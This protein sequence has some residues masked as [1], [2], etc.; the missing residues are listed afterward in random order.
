MTQI[1]REKALSEVIFRFQEQQQPQQGMVGNVPT[2]EE[3]TKA[4]KRNPRQT[5][6][7]ASTLLR[8]EILRWFKSRPTQTNND[9]PWQEPLGNFQT[10]LSKLLRL[11]CAEDIA[12]EDP[13]Q[14]KKTGRPLG[15]KHSFRQLWLKLDL[16]LDESAF[17][18]DAPLLFYLT[19]YTLIE[20]TINKVTDQELSTART[21]LPTHGEHLETGEAD[22][23]GDVTNEGDLEGYDQAPNES[24]LPTLQEFCSNVWQI[25]ALEL[26]FRPESNQA[27][28]SSGKTRPRRTAISPR[29][30]FIAEEIART[31]AEKKGLDLKKQMEFAG[32]LIDVLINSF[33]E[34]WFEIVKT[35]REDDNRSTKIQVIMPTPV[36]LNIIKQLSQETLTISH[37][38]PLIEPPIDWGRHGIQQGGYHYRHLPFYKF[39]WKNQKINEFLAK[40]N[41]PA[42][43]SEV[44][45]ATNVLQRTPWCIN[46]KV[47]RVVEAFYALAKVTLP[48]AANNDLFPTPELTTDTTVHPI[49]EQLSQLTPK[50]RAAWR[51][52]LRSD[53]NFYAREQGRAKG[54]GA[55]NAIRVT[56]STLLDALPRQRFYFAHQ[57][58][59]RGR[60][61]PVGSILQPQGDDL[62]RALL[63]FADALPITDAGIR[64]LAIYGS[65][66]IEDAAL[67]AYFRIQDRDKP[68]LEE[69]VRWI[70]AHTEEIVRCATAP[71][72]ETW[73]RGG[74][75]ENFVSKPFTFLAFCFA[76]ADYQQHGEQV[77][78]ALPVHV[79]GTCNGLQHIAA[80]MR[81]EGLAKATNVLPNDFPRDIYSEVA[82]AVRQRMLQPIKGKATTRKTREDNTGPVTNTGVIEFL[83]KFDHLIDRS[84]AKSVVMIIPYG[85]GQE[86]YQQNIYKKL[87]A[88]ILPKK[89]NNGYQ[90]NDYA[91]WIMA[92]LDHHPWEPKKTRTYKSND[93]M[94]R[95]VHR[96]NDWLKEVCAYHLAYHF[97]QAVQEEY[98]TINDFKKRLRKSIQPLCEHNVPALWVSPSGLP[99]LQNAFRVDP[100]IKEVKAEAITAIRFRLK[101]ISNDVSITNQSTGILP[102]FI[103][104]LDAAHLVKTMNLAQ[105]CNITH[106]STVHD[107]YATHAC[108]IDRLGDCIRDAFCE[109]YPPDQDRLENLE[110]WCEALLQKNASGKK[111]ALTPAERALMRMATA[112]FQEDYSAQKDKS[113]LDQ[114]DAEAKTQDNQKYWTDQVR[115]SRYFFS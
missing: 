43:F 93:P 27:T 86:N 108:Y 30:F 75:D 107:S 6:T 19:L 51:K 11:A 32:T 85:A 110:R 46:E 3:T 73:W 84:L 33:P 68:T 77:G 48:S 115:R 106:L 49:A 39:Y 96:L 69:R 74:E 63:Q 10:S 90:S 102:N 95:L 79:D 31:F 66:Q 42:W 88:K 40:V 113:K 50:Q 37:N 99:V 56:I 57:I 114:K 83:Q 45:A 35:I 61:Y 109:I 92:W 78:C 4:P 72:Q 55:R 14:P 87:S 89:V 111:P 53:D 25:I 2:A 41:V 18:E 91:K 59:A 1:K 24:D 97:N 13:T 60:L 16:G 80:L 103:H 112:W 38:A 54:P 58:D 36:L 64:P 44:F 20:N 23:K 7:M 76:W 105:A 5:A 15:T 17:K 81:D 28:K 100:H 21:L 70:E 98:P 8:R 71:L 34:K 26:S 52:W 101:Q 94:T 12:G 67:L 104:S 47:W 82:R 9:D 62:N 22:R 29:A 65:Q